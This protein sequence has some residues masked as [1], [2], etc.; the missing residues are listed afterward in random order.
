MAHRVAWLIYYKE[1]PSGH[2]DHKD[3]NKAN[4]KISNLRLA[5]YS[6]NNGNRKK[7]L[8]KSS[9][10]KGV[11]KTKWNTW[12]ASIRKDKK[13]FH[14]GTFNNELEAAMAYDKAAKELFGEFAKLNGVIS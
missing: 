14:L 12:K 13:G 9:V 6:Q 1:W 2:L 5:T 10:Y 3:G 4:I 11:S 8:G 7:S